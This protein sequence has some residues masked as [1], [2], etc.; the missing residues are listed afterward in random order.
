M[1]SLKEMKLVIQQ[2]LMEDIG[3]GDITADSIA[4]SAGQGIAI[5][6]AKQSGILAGIEPASLVFLEMD[7]QLKTS[8]L[9]KDGNSINNNDHI[10][11]ISGEIKSILKAERVALN[12]LAHLSGI[13]TLTNKFVQEIKDTKAQITD[14]RKTIPLLRKFE[15][16]AVQAGG[17]VNH[18]MGL[19][20][21]VLI[22][23]NHI[24]VSGGIKKAV[25]CV[26]QY[27]KAKNI[28]VKIEVETTNIMEVREALNCNVDRIMLDNMSLENI[29]EAVKIAAGKVEIEASGGITLNNVKLIAKTGVDLIS[30]GAIIHSAPAFDFTLLF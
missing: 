12:F 17:G 21:M 11:K 3:S 4:K 27:L 1:I 13:A 14:T 22:K 16:E 30:V 24:K 26:R 2:A 18:R 20:D 9:L 10:M 29:K 28:N 5:I 25:A 7:N 6:M 8:I 15:K 19:F 23:E